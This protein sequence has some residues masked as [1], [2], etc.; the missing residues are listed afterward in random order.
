VDSTFSGDERSVL[1]A[2]DAAWQQQQAPSLDAYLPPRDHPS[3]L[4]ILVGVVCID[5]ERRIKAGDTV[6]TEDY[7]DRFPELREDEDR[8][9]ELVL[10]EHEL[11]KQHGLDSHSDELP[12]RFPQLA[13]RL[14]DD[15]R[16]TVYPLFSGDCQVHVATGLDLR[17]YALLETLGQGGMGEVYR[18]RD[19]GLNR[20]L[21]LKVLRKKWQGHCEAEARFQQEAHITGSLQH[22]GVVPV[23]NLG[24]LPDGRLYFTMKVVQGRTFAQMLHEPGERTAEQ[25]AEDVV[26]FEKVCQTLAYAHSKGVIH[27]DVKPANIMA[28]A[29]GEVQVMDWGLAKI[30]DK[31]TGRRGDKEEATPLVSMSVCLA[32]TSQ[33][34]R[35]PTDVASPATDPAEEDSELETCPP[36]PPPTPGRI[37]SEGR[38]Q[39][40]VALGT[41][42]YMAPEQ[43]CGAVAELDERCDVFGLGALLCEMLTGQ[44]P[45][46]GPG[47]LELRYQ[48]MHAEL[49]PALERLDS[50]GADAELVALAKRCLAV[51][52]EQRPRDAGEI[53]RSVAGYLASVQQRLR[54]VERQRAAA[55][56]RVQAERQARRL[57]VGLAAAVLVVAFGAS[58][59]AW[60]AQQQ[61]ASARAR[62]T[63]TDQ[64]VLALLERGCVVLEEGWQAHD[65]AKLKEA[66]AEGVRAAD[67]ARKGD[68]SAV[69]QEQASEFQTKA[70]MQL[71]RAEKNRVLMDA[72]LNVSGPRETQLY[73]DG[74]AGQVL[75]VDYPSPDGLYAA[76]FRSWGLDIDHTP[77]AEIVARLRQ[78]PKVVL[79]EVTAALDAWLMLRRRNGDSEE[80]W[81]R[82]YRLADELDCNEQRRQLRALVS[83]KSLPAATHVAGLL[84]MTP[85][86]PA[87]WD[88]TRGHQWRRMEEL[89][90]GVDPTT[91]PVLTVVLLAQASHNVGDLAGAERVLRS[92]LAAKPDEVLLLASLGELLARQGSERLE[93]AIGCYRAIRARRPGL[94]VALAMA[95]SRAGNPEGEAVL[96]D[97]LH[98]QPKNPEL[99]V[100]FGT[101]LQARENHAGAEDAYRRAI[102]LK[103]DYPGAHNNLGVALEKRRKLAEA[104]ASFRKAIELKPDHAGAYTNLGLVLQAQRKLT[105]AEAAHRKAMRLNPDSPEIHTN[106]GT[107]LRALKKAAEAEAAYR[108]AIEIRP[109]FAPAQTNLGLLM[110]ELKRYPEAESAHRKAL[111]LKPSFAEA[112]SHL[113]ECLRVQKKLE[114][115]ESVIRT[116]IRLK[117]GL[118]EA[119]LN[120]G[121]VMADQK[122]LKA[123]EESVRKAIELDPDSAHAQHNLGFILRAQNKKTEAE[124]AFR[125]AIYLDADFADAHNGLGAVLGEKRELAAAEVALRTAIRIDPEHADAHNNLGNVLRLQKKRN[126]AIAE[127]RR[128]IELKPDNHLAHDNLGLALFELGKWREAESAFRKAVE[129]LPDYAVGHCN[130]SA[131]LLALKKPAAALATARKAIELRPNYLQ[132]YNNCGAAFQAMGKP[133]E[134]VEA[135]RQAIRL[136]SEYAEAHFGLGSVL[137]AQKKHKEAAAAYH[138][139]IRLKPDYPDAFYNLGILLREEN[140]LAEAEKAYRQAIQLRPDFAG[141]YTNLGN[142]LLVQGKLPQAEEAFRKTTLL[143]PDDAR[144]HYNLGNVLAAQK[145]H[146]AATAA[147]GKAIQL[148]HDFP[149]AHT[150]LG[151]VLHAQKKLP[152]AAT[153]LREAIKIKH[154]LPEAHWNLGLVL[155]EQASLENALAALS[156]GSELLSATH[157]AQPRMRRLVRQVQRQV[158]L[159]PR[160]SAVLQGTDKPTDAERIE[161]AQLCSLKKLTLA[162]VRLYIEA[163]TVDPKQAEDLRAGHRYSAACAA[164][165]AGCGQGKDA[166]KLDAHERSRLRQS[167]LRWLQADLALHGKRMSSGNSA[168]RASVDEKMRHWQSDSDLAGF[169][170]HD[171]LRKLPEDERR[172]WQK[173]WED[174]EALCKSAAGT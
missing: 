149:E 116:A 125:K 44:P 55:E 121:S 74:A 126:E 96:R 131:A 53:A 90:G 165:L 57:Q 156:K 88:L 93:E 172:Q 5:M 59:V 86:W 12:H 30:M 28:G 48:A 99:W 54:E 7:L 171:G 162:A 41:Y 84:A 69:V 139:A 81:S 143:K 85:P 11:R 158:N 71:A 1:D 82:L 127:C 18:S 106:L 147:F 144:A 170:D 56:V 68:A 108:K 20:D 174:V 83:G 159:A 75:A 97:L 142:L 31:E 21:A 24:R 107:A 80:K 132:S 128:S 161:F 29:F 77:E 154:D 60:I 50:C 14:P 173:L 51:K 146:N 27:R 19:P 52:P 76:A 117:P 79:D 61:R 94:G 148:Q 40:G 23:H 109:D 9:L 169:R 168:D 103:S 32:D 35:T 134:A 157:P 38:T 34:D 26:I 47:V 70:A 16:A 42:S 66:T 163:F 15:L 110:Q 105:E 100:Y 133:D 22:P 73:K 124:A 129:L 141:A 120:L 67:V 78:E 10:L 72:L 4:H 6:C 119:Y 130:L 91:Q 17:D 118:A 49:G 63:Q 150:N 98:H 58:S 152:E 89:R 136:D 115:A 37:G 64:D 39:S 153:A 43:A 167:A 13:E 45:Y 104:A 123:A 62:R 2:F 113:G 122:L 111:Q 137:F 138:R 114:E 87:V 95:L 101:A 36:L 151:T 135:Y 33:E 92:A 112:Y 164:A 25:R 166:D 160:L 46:T 140:K 155:L 3:R 102:A 145:K 8:L 65:V